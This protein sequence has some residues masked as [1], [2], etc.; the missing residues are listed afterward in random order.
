MTELE[1]LRA[2]GRI[3]AMTAVKPRKFY[4]TTAL[5]GRNPQICALKDVIRSRYLENHGRPRSG[6]WRWKLDEVG[7]PT[8]A[9]AEE[10]LAAAKALAYQ[11]TLTYRERHPEEYRRY[12]REY[13]RI[14]NSKKKNDGKDI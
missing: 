12:M 14:Y 13:M 7:P 3:Y 9:M 1:V 6:P 8:L 10:T 2:L 4:L 11:A 5:G